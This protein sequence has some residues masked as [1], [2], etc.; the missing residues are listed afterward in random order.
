MPDNRKTLLRTCYGLKGVALEI[1]YSLV[2]RNRPISEAVLIA[3]NAA[4][5]RAGTASPWAP[6]KE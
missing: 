1:A 6:R 2:L 5:I 4:A 3:R